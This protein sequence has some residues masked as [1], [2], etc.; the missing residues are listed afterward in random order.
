MT[1][2]LIGLIVWLL[3]SIPA[4]VFLGRIGKSREDKRIVTESTDKRRWLRVGF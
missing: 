1:Y 2:A 4:A 3:L